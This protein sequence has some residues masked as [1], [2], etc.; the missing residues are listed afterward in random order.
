MEHRSQAVGA[1]SRVS[2]DA[3]V[4]EDLDLL[5][6]VVVALVGNSLRILGSGKVCPGMC[7]V[8]IGFVGRLPT[9]A[10]LHFWR[11]RELLTKPVPEVCYVRDQVS[12]IERNFY[13][14]RRLRLP[15]Y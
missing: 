4:I 11:E 14:R 6:L 2:T 8:A 13:F 3:A 7:A 5:T 1:E 9:A 10:Q 15:R 12:T